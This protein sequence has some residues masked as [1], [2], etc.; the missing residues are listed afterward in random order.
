VLLS[1]KSKSSSRIYVMD[2]V[3]E[4]L[5]LAES[6]GATYTG[7]PDKQDVITEITQKEYSLLDVV[8]A[9]CGKQ[10]AINQAVYILKPGGKLMI[11]G[12]PEFDR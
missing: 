12:I 3:H 4:R 2:K 10:E 9:C 5:K 8:F 7:I 11:I 1:A 6:I